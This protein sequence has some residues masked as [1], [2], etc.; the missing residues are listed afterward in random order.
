MPKR[1]NTPLAARWGAIFGA[2]YIFWD[3]TRKSGLPVGTDGFAYLAGAIFAG[4][5]V[6]AAMFA[7]VSGLRNL[8]TGAK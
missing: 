3:T 2:A 1:W 6:G 7:A 4:A 8:I 5:V